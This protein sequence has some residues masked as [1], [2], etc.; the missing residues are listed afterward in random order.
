M[1]PITRVAL[2]DEDDVELVNSDW[3]PKREVRKRG[4]RR[5]TPPSTPATPGPSAPTSTP[6]STP[7]HE[8]KKI[9]PPPREDGIAERLEIREL[10]AAVVGADALMTKGSKGSWGAGLAEAVSASFKRPDEH[11]EAVRERKERDTEIA[12]IRKELQQAKQHAARLQSGKP[13][14]ATRTSGQSS[15]AEHSRVP[16]R[17]A[18]FGG[19]KEVILTEQEQR[20]AMASAEASAREG[21]LQSQIDML[22]EKN[23]LMSKEVT[24][25][26]RKAE[27]AQGETEAARAEASLYTS[28]K[29]SPVASM[30]TSGVNTPRSVSP[31]AVPGASKTATVVDA[32]LA[33][34]KKALGKK[35]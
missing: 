8:R 20:A 35:K 22:R 5:T 26:R 23:E 3:T 19:G 6:R 31:A 12:R 16:S 24:K 32:R 30:K 33:A 17:V 9:T 11:P 15:G 25:L 10:Q 21:S 28:I 27:R 34:V 13:P 4:P 2:V 29:P 1:T 7:V 18:M 14:R